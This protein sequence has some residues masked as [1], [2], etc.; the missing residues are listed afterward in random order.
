MII[1]KKSAYLIFLLLGSALI[2]H[3]LVYI[4]PGDPAMVI[5]GE[6][7][8]PED[9]E[10]IRNELALNESFIVRYLYY[11]SSLLKMDMGKSIYTGMPVFDTITDR[12]PATF[13]LAFT[14][15]AIAGIFG[16]LLG[17]VSSVYNGR[18]LDSLILSISSVFIS[19]PI[20]VTCFILL[21]IFSYY[22]SLLPPSGKMGFDPSYI[23]LPS[24]ALASRSLALIIR[25]VRNEMISV[26]KKDYIRTA[27]SLGFPEWKIIIIFSL[28]NIIVPAIAIILLDFGAYL[29]GAV[30]TESIFS[31]P[32]IGRLLIVALQKRDIPVIQG[33]ILFG[34]VLFIFIGFTIDMMQGRTAG[35][36]E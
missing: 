33:V 24:L 29:G 2:V 6:Y 18:A 30:V 35:G 14:A 1:L 36:A 26:L 22:L 5:A 10:A 16:I 34:T 21:L 12:L 27:R 20:F 25:V 15:M 4:I 32:G 11:I 31:W 28:K 8:S 19:T 23:V 7:A 3:T 17:L 13:I 9:V